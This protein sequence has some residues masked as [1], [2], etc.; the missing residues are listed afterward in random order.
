MT[1]FEN[2]LKVGKAKVKFGD[3]DEV[4]AM[5]VTLP[6]FFEAKPG[7]PNSMDGDVFD[8]IESMFQ[9]GE[10]KEIEVI[11]EILKAEVAQL[12]IV[13]PSLEKEMPMKVCYEMPIKKM[14]SHLKPLYVSAHFD[15]IPIAKF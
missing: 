3:F 2:E 7:Q 5:V 12:Q 11:R 13:V 14:A 9:M 6:L 15:G 1:K 4:E 10:L 8:E